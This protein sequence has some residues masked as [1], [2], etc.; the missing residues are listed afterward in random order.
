MPDWNG[1]GR[2]SIFGKRRK[3]IGP[4]AESCNEGGRMTL[5]ASMISLSSPKEERVGVRRAQLQNREL[6]NGK[7]AF[8]SNP[9]PRPNG[10]PSPPRDGFPIRDVRFAKRGPRLVAGR[11]RPVSRA[12]SSSDAGPID[13]QKMRCAQRASPRLWRDGKPAL[14]GCSRTPATVQAMITARTIITAM[15]HHT[16]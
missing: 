2:I 5:T 9:S 14:Y 13:A 16:Q 10:F 12:V 3:C 7:Q 11:G 6:A 1:R 4:A 15:I 8:V